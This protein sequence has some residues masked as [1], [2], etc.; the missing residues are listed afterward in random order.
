MV[1]FFIHSF[2]LRQRERKTPRLKRE[3]NKAIVFQVVNFI[4]YDFVLR[5]FYCLWIFYFVRR[6]TNKKRDGRHRCG[7]AVDLTYMGMDHFGWMS[8]NVAVFEA[9]QG[10]LSFGCQSTLELRILSM[11]PQDCNDTFCLWL[12]YFFCQKSPFGNVTH[13]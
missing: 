2:N 3:R 9:I 10:L 13:A 7:R 5:C 6:L 12:F 4:L 1:F 8:G 11:L